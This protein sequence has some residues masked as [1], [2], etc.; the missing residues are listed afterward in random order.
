MGPA[1]RTRPAQLQ[2]RVPCERRGDPSE[3]GR[4]DIVRQRRQRADLGPQ[5]KHLHPPAHPGGRRPRALHLRGQ[6][7]HHASGRQQ[8][9]QL[10]RVADD[11]YKG[12]DCPAPHHQVQITRQAHYKG[13]AVARREAPGHMLGGLHG[14]HLVD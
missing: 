10:L 12:R 1:D 11:E 6:R 8:Q 14:A 2:A 5:R 3:P 9:G 7:R 4:A 13:A